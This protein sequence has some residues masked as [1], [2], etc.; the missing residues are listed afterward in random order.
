MLVKLRHNNYVIL[1]NITNLLGVKGSLQGFLQ[2]LAVVTTR[3]M[4]IE[5]INLVMKMQAG[6]T[7]VMLRFHIRRFSVFTIVLI[8]M[9]Q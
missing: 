3:P 9:G 5:Q 6:E 2:Q 8:L 1:R 7:D 4:T